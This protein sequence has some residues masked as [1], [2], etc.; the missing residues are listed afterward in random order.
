MLVYAAGERSERL[1][2]PDT[3]KAQMSARIRPGMVL[4]S[5]MG[6]ALVSVTGSSLNWHDA[7]T[8]HGVDRDLAKYGASAYAAD[9]NDWKRSARDGLLLELAKHDLSARDLHASVSWFTKVAPSGDERG[10][11]AF[12]AGH[13]TAGDWVE[14]RTELDVLVVLSTS[15]HPMDPSPTWQPAAVEVS[16]SK[17]SPPGDDDPCRTFR[18]ESGRALALAERGLA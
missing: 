4:M 8:G 15:P 2:V 12:A 18:A 14:L 9:R 7:I 11:L 10:T 5:D 17:A 6:R 3:L 16:I 13:A 1:N